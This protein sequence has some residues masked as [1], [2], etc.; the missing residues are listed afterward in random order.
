MAH[1][2]YEKSGAPSPLTPDADRRY[3]RGNP[4]TGRATLSTVDDTMG[5]SPNE[6]TA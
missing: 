2:R 6:L 5:A 3:R 4:S 1:P